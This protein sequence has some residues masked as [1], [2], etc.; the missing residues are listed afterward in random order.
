MTRSCGGRRTRMTGPP[1][2]PMDAF[3]FAP[4]VETSCV[5]SPAARTGRQH[6]RRR[7]ARR[8]CA[9]G[10]S[11]R[12][13]R[14][15]DRAS[16][17]SAARCAGS[18]RQESGRASASRPHPGQIPCCPGGLGS[19]AGARRPGNRASRRAQRLPRPPPSR[20]G[21]P[22]RPRRCQYPPPPRP[23]GRSIQAGRAQPI[24]PNKEF[25]DRGMTNSET[26]R[27]SGA[28]PGPA[29]GRLAQ[30]ARQGLGRSVAVPRGRSTWVWCG[31]PWAR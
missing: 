28:G 18:S 4:A 20:R 22:Q 26:F 8:R 6:Q 14:R 29:S 13:G 10:Q 16:P 15:G 27:T 30:N 1:A 23:Y 3:R 21:A 12:P 24:A 17:G 7:H 11:P 19:T 9:G 5:P 31:A 25:Q 2:Y